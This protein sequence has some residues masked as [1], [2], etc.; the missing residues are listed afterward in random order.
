MRGLGPGVEP[1]EGASPP[2]ASEAADL[3]K[4]NR[5]GFD[6]RETDVLDEDTGETSTPEL[7]MERV[8]AGSNKDAMGGRDVLLPE[9]APGA[10]LPP[11]GAAE[12]AMGTVVP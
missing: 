8:A 6:K 5:P 4:F 9:T 3:A 12:E 11:M 2:F 1:A 10:A 7:G